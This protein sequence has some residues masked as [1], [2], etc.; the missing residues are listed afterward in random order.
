MP[1][2]SN[3]SYLPKVIYIM[4][5]AR[6]G[7][8]L[9][10]ILLANAK[11]VFAAGELT[12]L[13]DEGFIND[14][15]CSC[16]Q[17]VSKCTVWGEVKKNLNLDD[18]ELHKWAQLQKNID[19]HDGFFRQLFGIITKKNIRPSPSLHTRIIIKLECITLWCVEFRLLQIFQCRSRQD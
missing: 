19:W 11:G 3:H 8:T 13:I 16:K 10:E 2:P 9:L 6:S 12:S 5:T 7:S 15:I 4:G 18:A 17:A 14:K 1:L